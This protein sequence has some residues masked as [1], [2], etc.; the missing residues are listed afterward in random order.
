ME[1]IL[2]WTD[3]QTYATMEEAASLLE[4]LREN[5]LNYNVVEDAHQSGDS[6]NLGFVNHGISTVHVQ[7]MPHDMPTASRILDLLAGKE[8]DQVDDDDYISKFSNTELL[9]VLKQPDEWSRSDVQLA[10]KFL[11]ERGHKVTEEDVN[12]WMQ[13]RL[14]TMAKPD[15]AGRGLLLAGYGL[16]LFGG[17][18]GL[19]IGLQLATFHKRLPDGN[20]PPMYIP[21]DRLHGRI[22]AALSIPVMFGIGWFILHR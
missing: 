22:I 8:M 3:L 21:S 2:E 13:E 15:T 10:F 7:V 4:L 16:A 12:R 9:E 17:I 11:N 6:L 1:K 20:K 5:N 18:F 14:V 19:I